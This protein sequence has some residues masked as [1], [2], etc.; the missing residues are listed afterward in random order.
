MLKSVGVV[1][2]SYVL[3]ILLVLGTDPL[4]SAVFPGDFERGRVPSG[5]ALL[6]STICF[7]LASIICA[8]VCAKFAPGRAGWHVFWFFVLGEVLGIATTIPNWNKGWPHWYALAWL[9]TWPASCWI[10]L[11]LA[12]R[13]ESRVTA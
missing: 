6:A 4:L 1:L 7:V 5:K 9:L 2:G 13:R 10:G 11:K 8:W 12:G 3:S